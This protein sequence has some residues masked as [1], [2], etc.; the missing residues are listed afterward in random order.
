MTAEEVL[1]KA[2]IDN[3]MDNL[4]NPHGWNPTVTLFGYQQ[5][6]SFYIATRPASILGDPVGCH[7]KG[8]LLIK[9]DGR[10][11]PVE[12][13]Q[14]GDQLMGPDSNPRKV[15]V[16]HQPTTVT[17]CVCTKHNG[18]FTVSYNH[19]LTLQRA[20]DSTPID[21]SIDDYLQLPDLK[22]KE[23]RLFSVP[24][25]NTRAPSRP[26]SEVRNQAK[27]MVR[28][29]HTN[30][31]QPVIDPLWLETEP[32][33]RATLLREI[34]NVLRPETI[35]TGSRLSFSTYE[36]AEFTN[37]LA[38]SLGLGTR[39]LN[40]GPAADLYIR[41]ATDN[42]P[43]QTKFEVLLLPDEQTFYGFT[44]DGDG[45]Y[46]MGNGFVTH[47]SG[48]TIVGTHAWGLSRDRGQKAGRTPRLWV[49]ANKA[50]T[51]QWEGELDRLIHGMNIYRAPTENTKAARVEI[52]RDFAADKTSPVLIT[53]WSQAQADWPELKAINTE[54]PFLHDTFLLL[55]EVQKLGNPETA[56][57]QAFQEILLRVPNKLGL[58]AT[59]I[60]NTPMNLW[61]V[62][63]AIK[64]GFLPKDEFIHKYCVMGEQ[65]IRM[66]GRPMTITV[67]KDYKNL[68]DLKAKI[69]PLY[70]GR[71]DAEIQS[72]RPEVVIKQ[73][74]LPLLPDQRK[75]YAELETGALLTTSDDTG[76]YA[77]SHA[78]IG[79]AAPQAYAGRTELNHHCTSNAK[80]EFVKS[81]LDGDLKGEK[82]VYYSQLETVVSAY[83]KDIAAHDPTIKPLRI[84]GVEDDPTRH[85]NKVAFTTGDNRAMLITNA[86][87]ESL[88]LQAAKYIVFLTL[89]WDPAT[90]IQV[91]GRIR[92]VGSNHATI[93]V[94]VLIADD[95][96]DEY[97]AAVLRDKTEDFK[98]VIDSNAPSIQ[99]TSG[100]T[101]QLLGE[102][103]RRRMKHSRPGANP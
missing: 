71:V 27:A 55:D 3:R 65:R 77:L 52:Y 87:A 34:Y 97:I 17:A 73:V 78:M 42:H 40:R 11:V 90:F 98:A 8:T 95:T 101:K 37:N 61:A 47:N 13:I 75:T 2:L 88:N 33:T 39:L 35:P 50:A 19:I 30:Q 24:I 6:G 51:L 58:T 69:T 7:T 10:R 5:V 49:V 102:L 82:V 46:V 20:G 64:P 63:H 84:T 89:P 70:L 12:S 91:I 38:R 72:Q 57:Y 93:V 25:N 22:K 54:T 32:D 59:L 100:L 56:L 103:R 85:A 18:S 28:P 16:L 21:I 68:A 41:K 80:L 76:V 45:R 74:R 44:L 4:K 43:C 79:A 83:E 62:I 92:R 81:L 23:L 67:V 96:I 94:Y 86:G 60:R 14:P 53:N 31:T 66:R 9:A 26:L 1:T 48:K 15:L 99:D 29:S 36:P